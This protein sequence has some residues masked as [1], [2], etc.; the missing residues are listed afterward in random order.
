MLA[1]MDNKDA[2]EAENQRLQAAVGE[3][4]T[5]LAAAEEALEEQRQ[6]ADNRAERDQ[7]VIEDLQR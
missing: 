3:L 7:A 6:R 1:V 4:T 5:R 2:V